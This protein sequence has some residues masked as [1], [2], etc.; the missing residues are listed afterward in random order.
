M[1]ILCILQA[2]CKHIVMPHFPP[3][4]KVTFCISVSA[5]MAHSIKVAHLVCHL[6]KSTMFFPREFVLWF[7]LEFALLF[8]PGSAVVC[9]F[10]VS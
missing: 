3:F 10:W 2:V 9:S 4:L 1:S 7:F 6:A 5:S 8:F